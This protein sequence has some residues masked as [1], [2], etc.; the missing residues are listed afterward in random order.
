MHT[1]HPRRSRF[2]GLSAALIALTLTSAG[3]TAAASGG[4]DT[5]STATV[6]VTGGAIHGMSTSWGF[7]FR[8]IPYAAPPTG[9]AVAPAAASRR[10]KGVRDATRFA[11]SCPQAP[12]P[13]SPP[14][15]LS[16]NCLASTCRRRRC[17]QCAPAGAGVDPRRRLPQDAARNYDGAKLAPR[18]TCRRH[19]QLP[20]GRAR[21]SRPSRARHSPR[22]RRQLR[23]DGPAGGAALGE[24]EHRAV[25]RRPGQRH[26][27][28]PVGR[29]RLGAGADGLAR[30]SWTLP[31]RNRAERRFRAAPA[32][33]GQAE[34]AGEA[35]AAKAGCPTQTARCLRHLPVRQP[36]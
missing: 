19:P 16:E 31:A 26:A 6:A 7:A 3:A 11:P 34:A 18:G 29:R 15:R 20:P 10:W 8:G 4:A 17:G 36:R 14:G 30:R 25:R 1:P 28:R 23:T 35:F 12:S 5:P 9:S 33:A 2:A 27:R 21:L 13:L 32:V 22:H 24:A